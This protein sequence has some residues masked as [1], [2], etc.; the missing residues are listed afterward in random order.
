MTMWTHPTAIPDVCVVEPQVFGDARG[1][2]MEVWQAQRFARAG[3]DIDFVQDNRSRS[4]G[5]ILRGLH[6][7]LER[8]QGKLVGVVAGE[9]FDV[10]V[11]MRRSSP[12]FGRW[13]GVTLSEHNHFMLW[14]PPGFAHG[15]Y[16]TSDSADFFYKCS[17][18]YAPE[19]EHTVVWNDPDLG[20]DWPLIAGEHP[21]ISDKDAD[22][23][24]F[25]NA[26]CFP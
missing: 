22:G 4:A 10:A 1:H 16:V 18:Y 12:T 3:L 6:Y 2:F 15:F 24:A 19:D 8:P 21:R 20:I 14:V 7:Q 25:Q 26:L 9:V 13:V 23:A 11:D 17:D 5:G